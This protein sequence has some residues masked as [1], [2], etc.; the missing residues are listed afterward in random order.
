MTSVE[1]IEIIT[2][3]PILVIYSCVTTLGSQAPARASSLNN[4]PRGVT[5]AVEAVLVIFGY[6]RGLIDPSTPCAASSPV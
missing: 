1:V 5:K 6:G 3:T 4:D 2:L